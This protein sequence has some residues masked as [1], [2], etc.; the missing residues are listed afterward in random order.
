MILL[1]TSSVEIDTVLNKIEKYEK[2][3]FEFFNAV[4]KH[5]LFESLKNS[6]E[7]TGN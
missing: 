6:E 7:F 2:K 5:I 1:A 3:F 4:C